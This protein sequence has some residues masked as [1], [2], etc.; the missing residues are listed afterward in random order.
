MAKTGEELSEGLVALPEIDL[1]VEAKGSTEVN[2]VRK[3]KEEVALGK[4]SCFENSS[5]P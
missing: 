3:S 4:M 1:D 5:A 2:E